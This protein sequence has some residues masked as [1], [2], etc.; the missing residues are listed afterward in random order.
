MVSPDLSIPAADKIIK[1]RMIFGFLWHISALLLQI[2]SKY[3]KF[4][5]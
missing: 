1:I 5:I 3:S 2:M 4:V